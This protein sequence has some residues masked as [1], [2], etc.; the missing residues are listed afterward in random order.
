MNRAAVAFRT[1]WRRHRLLVLAFLAALALTVGFGVRSAL[2]MPDFRAPP[3]DPP[4]EGWM[5]PRL[6]ARGWH[7][8]PEVLGAALGLEPGAGKR[9]TLDQ[10]A[11]GQGITIDELAARIEAAALAYRRDHPPP[12]PPPVPPPEPPG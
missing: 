1:L 3:A 9:R 10:I 4:I 2:F 12:A 6:V 5:T 11:A 8:P 7:L